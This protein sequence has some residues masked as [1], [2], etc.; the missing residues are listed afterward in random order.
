MLGFMI[1]AA[2][3]IESKAHHQNNGSIAGWA[4]VNV[5]KSIVALE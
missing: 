3:V 2:A 1:A 4:L 5:C